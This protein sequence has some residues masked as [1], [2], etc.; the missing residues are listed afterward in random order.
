M[1]LDQGQINHAKYAAVLQHGEQVLKAAGLK[2]LAYNE[3]DNSIWLNGVADWSDW[4]LIINIVVDGKRIR[5]SVRPKFKN[6][7][8]WEKHHAQ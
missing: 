3:R 4:R 8:D 2:R 5:R 1:L 7:E 6:Q